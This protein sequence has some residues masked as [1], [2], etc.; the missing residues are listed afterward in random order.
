MSNFELQLIKKQLDQRNERMH[1]DVKSIKDDI[2]G[3]K[4]KLR[5]MKNNQQGQKHT[6]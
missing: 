6:F 4:T 3:M 2:S 1:M 5:D